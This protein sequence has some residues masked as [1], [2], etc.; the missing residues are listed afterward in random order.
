MRIEEIRVNCKIGVNLPKC[1]AARSKLRLS[2]KM[3][4]KIKERERESSSMLKYTCSAFSRNSENIQV[5]DITLIRE[6]IVY[7]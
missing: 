3:N 7:M 5:V 6:R 4:M 1:F 2:Y